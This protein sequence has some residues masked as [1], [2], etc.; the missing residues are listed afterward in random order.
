MPRCKCLR[1]DH[2]RARFEGTRKQDAKDSDNEN[3]DARDDQKAGI[4]N[5]YRAPELHFH[6]PQLYCK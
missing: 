4:N 3:D 1:I 2:E 6:S 5:H